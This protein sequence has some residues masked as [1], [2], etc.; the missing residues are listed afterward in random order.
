MAT[1]EH[2][3]M[4][5]YF[6]PRRSLKDRF[7]E[8][9]D[10][11]AVPDCKNEKTNKLVMGFVV[12]FLCDYLQILETD[13]VNIQN[14][15][16]TKVRKLEVEKIPRI[17]KAALGGKTEG[18]SD[19]FGVQCL[20]D[21]RATAGLFKEVAFNERFEKYA[22]QFAGVDLG[23]GTGILGSAIAIA[24]LR[25]QYRQP[26][27]ALVDSQKNALDNSERVLSPIK[28]VD[29]RP[30]RND[31]RAP[32]LYGLFAPP[33]WIKYWVSETFGYTTPDIVKL[34]KTEL[35]WGDGSAIS[36]EISGAL[37]PYMDVLAN[38]MRY[39]PSFY[40]RA[41]QGKA[42]LFPDP[43]NGHFLPDHGNGRI[44]LKTGPDPMPVGFRDIR[45]EFESF[46]DFSVAN[47]RWG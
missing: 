32:Q 21:V 7:D 44:L 37:D 22:Q 40:D 35:E 41:K 18:A 43:I 29:F 45:K 46:E 42:A 17:S 4:N 1:S 28:S 9:S 38:L 3:R 11:S 5:G 16:R 26:L 13:V 12:K 31:L 2:H 24:A 10:P 23:S 36:K 14:N 25:N 33:I 47:I 20:A 30:I 39:S 8:L 27:V 34:S 19:A 15:V 6:D